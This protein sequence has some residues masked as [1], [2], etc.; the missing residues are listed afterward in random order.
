MFVLLLTILLNIELSKC[1]CVRH[2]SHIVLT[3]LL[4]LM[5][6]NHGSTEMLSELTKVPEQVPGQTRVSTQGF[7][8]PFIV[9]FTLILLFSK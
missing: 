2:L 4:D 7:L 6:G 3:V 1:F 9:L 8:F 5:I